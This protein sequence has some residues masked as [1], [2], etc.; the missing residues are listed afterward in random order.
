MLLQMKIS[1]NK[2]KK[3]QQTAKKENLSNRDKWK[4]QQQMNSQLF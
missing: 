2:Y 4:K 3:K 1:K